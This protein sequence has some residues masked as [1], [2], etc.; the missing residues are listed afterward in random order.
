MLLFRLF[1]LLQL[2][3]STPKKVPQLPLLPPMLTSCRQ[4]YC[5]KQ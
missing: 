4:A 2:L 5:A 1:M 3:G